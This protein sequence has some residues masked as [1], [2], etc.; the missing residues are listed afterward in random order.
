MRQ[1]RPFFERMGVQQHMPQAGAAEQLALF[2]FLAVRAHG[3]VKWFMERSACD[4]ACAAMCARPRRNDTRERAAN[5]THVR[6]EFGHERE[7]R[8]SD[9]SAY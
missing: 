4:H 3:D 5:G 7:Q 9:R 2:F 1:C 8:A 6:H